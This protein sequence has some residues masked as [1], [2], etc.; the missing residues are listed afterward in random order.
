MSATLIPDLSPSLKDWAQIFAWGAAVI[1]VGVAFVKARVEIRENREQR[2]RELR[3]QQANAGKHLVDEL[4]SDEYSD[5]ALTMLDWSGLE[6]E[7][8]PKERVVVTREDYVSALR[9]EN[10]NF[11]EKEQYIRDCFDTL[12]YY[13]GTMQHH[14]ENAL[15]RFDD[16]V[17]PLDYYANRMRHDADL[18]RRFLDYYR[19]GRERRFLDRLLATAEKVPESGERQGPGRVHGRRAGRPPGA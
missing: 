16:V 6:Y 3:W 15:V 17:Y 18:F 5:A 1:G 13:M 11:T 10:L 2:A 19:L 7:I 12:F 8:T 14:E 9:V 4:L